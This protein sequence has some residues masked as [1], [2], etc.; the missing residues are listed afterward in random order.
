M[1]KNLP[2]IATL[3]AAAIAGG[4]SVA[5][6]QAPDAKVKIETKV[7]SKDQTEKNLSSA[8][9]DTSRAKGTARKWAQEQSDI[10]ADG[11]TLYGTLENGMRYVIH[12]NALPPERVSF[13]LHVDAG[14]LSES[15]SQRGVAH[16]LEHMVFNGTKS[17][18]D[19]TK[20]VPQMQRLGIAFG[21][22]AN[23]YTSFDETVYMLDLPDVKKSTI[24]LAFNVMGDFADGALLTDEE[25]DEERGVISSEKTSRDSINMRMM[26]KQFEHLM[27]NSLLPK[28]FPIGTDEVIAKAPRAEFVDFYTRYYTPEKMTFIVVGDIDVAEMEQRVHDH[29]GGIKNPAEPGKPG[30]VG[31]VS[32]AK[33]F[34]TAVFSDKELT[35]TDVSLIQ[36]RAKEK[37]I[38]S[39]AN[40]AEK[41]PLGIA[42]A[43]INRR[44]SRLAKKENALI[45]SGSI[46]SSLFFREAEIGSIDVTA[47]DGN[48]QAVVP[49]LEQ[50]LRRAVEHGFTQSEIDEITAGMM[51]SYEQNV[52]RAATKKTDSIASSIA[53]HI[54]GDFV[55][56]TPEDDLA[57]F[58]ENLKLVTPE[59]CH[60]ALKDFWNTEDMTLVL[61][62]PE[63]PENAEKS[64]AALYQ[65]SKLAKV[66]AEVQKEVAEFGYTDFG[67][68]GTVESNNHIADLDIYQLEFSNGVKV[69]YKKTDFDKNQIL[70]SSSF[71]TGKLGMPQDKSGLDML[72]G[73]VA[74]GGGLGKHSADDL[75]TLLAGKNVGVGLGIGDDSFSIGGATTPDDLELQLQLLCASLTD[76][77]FRPEAERQF[78]AQLPMLFSQLKHS[79][80]GA[81]AKMSGWLHGDDGRF[82]V[83]T[84]EQAQ[85]LGTADVVNW[86]KPQM[87]ESALEIGIVGDIDTKK[88]I[89]LLAKTVGAL[90]ARK[91][92]EE[93]ADSLRAITIPETPVTKKFGFES[94]VPTAVS[95]VGWKAEDNTDHDV[96][97]ARRAGILAEIL[98]DRMRVKL[99]EELGDAYSPGA[100]S[101]LSETYKN[102]GF[103]LAYSPVKPEDLDN[104]SEVIVALGAKFAKEG[105]TEDELKRALTPR[106]GMLTKSLRQNSY[107][108]GS[109]VAE[110]QTK[111]YVLDWARGRDADYKSINLEDINALAKKYLTSDRAMSIKIAPDAA[112]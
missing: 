97:L 108:L 52:V 26:E 43:I 104:V 2:L 29:F 10:K 21:A 96:K 70:I 14:S 41:L 60:K 34:H 88:L 23:A 48:W 103:V 79:A 98:S 37:V 109:V 112:K 107:W 64:L 39:K 99:R 4:I 63:E 80:G 67:K 71:G 55:Y 18:P 9:S 58:Q 85:A 50:E 15:D 22:H 32:G 82:T 102:V 35:S 20:L 11:K 59:A 89:P 68:S 73:A 65:R 6:T 17:F 16:F 83:P 110:S 8:K 81:Q 78:K 40:R 106:I 86:M 28:R 105:A 31:D 69:N 1:K 49:V 72:A 45:T 47:K 44:F 75:R 101:Q 5:Q 90:P 53:K 33:G 13:R 62:I 91:P 61:S 56:S 94:K 42:H 84:I 93:V 66:E 57:I 25:I 111:P 38:D 100:G 24:D 95:I 92:A 19:A 7:E 27:P 77:G 36:V 76:P 46:S 51:N 3:S 74:N 30:T 87:L 12:K 54:H